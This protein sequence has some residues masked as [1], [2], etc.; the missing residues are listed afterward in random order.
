MNNAQRAERASN[1]IALHDGDCL[2]DLLADIL[3]LCAQEK[4]NFERELDRARNH[5]DF[6]TKE[7]QDA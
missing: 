7:E 1:A 4:I 6:E 3:H 5:Y 2:A